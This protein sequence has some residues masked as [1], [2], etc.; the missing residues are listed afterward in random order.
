MKPGAV[1]EQPVRV[2]GRLRIETKQRLCDGMSTAR[3][4]V[5][6]AHCAPQR[7]QARHEAEARVNA[8]ACEGL[9]QR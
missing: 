5:C 9:G 3:G 6:S 7:G 1:A 2:A 4:G 8:C